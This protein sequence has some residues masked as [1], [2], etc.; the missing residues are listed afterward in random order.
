MSLVITV[1]VVSTISKPYVFNIH[2][3]WQILGSTAQLAT[4]KG[5][6]LLEETFFGWLGSAP[7]PPTVQFVMPITDTLEQGMSLE[8]ERCILV[9]RMSGF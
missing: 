2:S 8:A 4:F 3:C 5:I 9:L 1:Y 7:L 6:S